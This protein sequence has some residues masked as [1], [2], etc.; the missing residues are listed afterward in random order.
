MERICQKSYRV[1]KSNGRM[2][3][4]APTSFIVFPSIN[5]VSS[6]RTKPWQVFLQADPNKK[7]C[8]ALYRPTFC[9]SVSQCLC[10]PHNLPPSFVSLALIH[11]IFSPLTSYVWHVARLPGPGPCSVFYPMV[12]CFFLSAPLPDAFWLQ[13]RAQLSIKHLPSRRQSS[14]IQFKERKNKTEQK[15]IPKIFE[16]GSVWKIKTGKCWVYKITSP[17]VLE[18]TLQS[19]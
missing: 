7:V 13:T 16:I 17:T 14:A 8:L 19:S 10:L 5:L 1:L 9:M 15:K 4:T 2:L 6:V 12:L 18:R 3:E 11:C